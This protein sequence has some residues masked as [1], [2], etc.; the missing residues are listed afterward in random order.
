MMRLNLKFISKTLSLSILILFSP[1]NMAVSISDGVKAIND[2]D[3][4]AAV[5]IWTQLAKSG[6]TVAKYNLAKHYSAGSGVNKSNQAADQWL[7]GAT[8]SG[9]IEAYLN[10]NKQAIAPANGVTLSFSVDPVLWLSKQAPNEYTIQLS[11]SRN[12]KSIKKSYYDNNIKDKGGYYHYVRDDVD[13][14]ALIYGSYKTVAEANI[15]IKK[16]PSDLK[17]T[18]PWVRKIKSLQNISK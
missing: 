17:K 1:Q 7:K 2:N 12:E 13:R 16:L 15:A 8:R 5:K 11:S 18:T 14:Y 10:L 6:N 3:N 9:L 4:I